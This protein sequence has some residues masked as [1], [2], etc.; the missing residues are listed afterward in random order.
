MTFKEKTENFFYYYKWH[1]IIGAVV[2]L[3]VGYAVVSSLGS[4]EPD[5]YM[6]YAS[7]KGVSTDTSDKLENMLSGAGLIKDIDGDGTEKMIFDP[8]VVD[9]E[10]NGGGDYMMLQKLQTVL[11]AGTQTVMFVHRYIVEDYNGV[12]EDLAE[13][14]P[15]GAETIAGP[16]G[17]VSAISVQ[18][19][20]KLESCGI[21]TENLFIGIR[22]RT[23]KQV[24]KGEFEKEYDAAYDVIK[25]ILN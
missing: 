9:M 8:M 15:D 21:N 18:G 3:V 4:H 14:V 7:D 17:G 6:I 16:D 19:N 5:L 11:L 23:D 20:K 13:Y 10:S 22:R 25:F 12:F 1:L 24:K 2:A